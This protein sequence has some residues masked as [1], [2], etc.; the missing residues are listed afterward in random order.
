LKI[1]TVYRISTFVPPEHV[2]ALLEGILKVAPLTYGNY[3]HVAWCS[4]PGVEQFNPLPGSRLS[5][6]QQKVIEKNRSIKLEF[7]IPRDEELLHRVLVDGIA[8]HH[9]WEEPVIYVSESLST[10]TRCDEE[11]Q[12]CEEE[13]LLE[14]S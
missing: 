8:A 14:A 5:F 12:L 13:Q 11:E 10:R 4:A 3:D 6:G 7:S 1:K 9:P 2:D